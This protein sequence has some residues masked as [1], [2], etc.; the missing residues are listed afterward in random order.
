LEDKGLQFLYDELK[1]FD[2]FFAESIHPNDK[3]R[4]LR[5]LEVFKGSGIPLSWYHKHGKTGKSSWDVLYIGLEL[6]REKL[7][8]RIEKRVDG[9][10]D[11]GLVNE[12]IDLRKK[13]YGPK[14]KSMQS[15]GY[16]EINRYLDGLEDIDSS[17]ESIKRASRQ[18][19]K[20]QMTW[21]RKNKLMKWHHADDLESVRN[22]LSKWLM[23]SFK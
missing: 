4:I 21:F 12:V 11:D 16:L 18:Y 13:G 20:R 5:G 6:P 3:Q 14:L 19:A 2:L 9:M 22:I 17:I 10:I 7:S 1:R 8:M 15:I 23:M